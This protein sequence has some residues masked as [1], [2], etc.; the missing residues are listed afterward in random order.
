[1]HF[2][3]ALQ[4]LNANMNTGPYISLVYSSKPVV[5]LNIPGHTSV[6]HITMKCQLDM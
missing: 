3:I 5:P 4:T 6:K 1:M 2:L